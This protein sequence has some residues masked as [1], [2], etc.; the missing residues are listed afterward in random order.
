[1]K[2]ETPQERA[3]EL[4]KILRRMFDPQAKEE[5]VIDILSDLRHLCDMRGWDFGELDRIA[6]QHYVPEKREQTITV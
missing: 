1:M 5:N 2:G 6:Y 4:E 3:K